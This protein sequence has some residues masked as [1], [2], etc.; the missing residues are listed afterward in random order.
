MLKKS[1]KGC[2]RDQQTTE[3][4]PKTLLE[5]FRQLYKPNIQTQIPAIYLSMLH[6]LGLNYVYTL[7]LYKLYINLKLWF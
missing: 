2:S 4:C 7:D 1:A 5:A 3:S 6:M